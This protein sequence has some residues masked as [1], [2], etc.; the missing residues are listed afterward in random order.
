MITVSGPVPN[1][2]TVFAV[3]RSALLPYVPAGIDMIR[4]QVNR[5]PEPSGPDFLVFWPTSRTNLET[6]IQSYH[7]GY[8]DDPPTPGVTTVYQPAELMVQI[9]VHGPASGDNVA[10]LSALSR[11][12]VLAES[13]TAITEDVAVLYASEARQNPFEN[14]ESQTEWMWSIDFHLQVNATITLAQDYFDQAEAGIFNVDVEY[15]P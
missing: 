4:G 12:L 13:M 8:Y 10:I 1:E 2:S 14:A 5:V 9:D 11:S 7:D 3:L 15:P 6:P